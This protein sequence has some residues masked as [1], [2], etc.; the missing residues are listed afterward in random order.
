MSANIVLGL[1]IG[2]IVAFFLI[3]I[4]E[5]AISEIAEKLERRKEKR[6]DEIKV[7]QISANICDMFEDVLDRCGIDIPSEDR[8]GD[9]AE[10]HLYG[11]VYS[12]LEDLVTSAVADAIR[13]GQENPQA[14]LNVV[15][16]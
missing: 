9:E 1:S 12:D 15:E 16:Y 14:E 8:E 5:I 13:L 7:R 10:A 11:D 6:M 3:L 4:G 2:A